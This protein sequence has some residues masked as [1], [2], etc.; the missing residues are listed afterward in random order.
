MARLSQYEE[1]EIR[2]IEKKMKVNK[3]YEIMFQFYEI[4]S[5][6]SPDSSLYN[7]YKMMGAL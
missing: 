7:C 6:F 1:R 5:S 4:C 2:E 3:T